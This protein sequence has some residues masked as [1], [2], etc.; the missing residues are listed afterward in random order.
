MEEDI[1]AAYERFLSMSHLR[2]TKQRR[3]IFETF[4]E[5]EE[6]FTAEG[7]YHL[8]QKVLPQI[9]QATIYRTLKLL[10]ENGFAR[11]LNLQLQGTQGLHSQSC[12]FEPL[13]SAHHDHLVCTECNRHFEFRNEELEEL[14]IKIAAE[15][16]FQLNSH[17]HVLYG[18]CHNCNS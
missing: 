10:C 6:H 9:G 8:L 5:R 14:Q 13:S 18:K 7:L 1:S 3:L 17:T 11:E 2:D 4:M 16:N 12:Y 15:H